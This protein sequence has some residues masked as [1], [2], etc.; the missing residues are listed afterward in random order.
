[1]SVRQSLLALLDGGESYGYQLR[2]EF[3]RRTGGTWPVNIGQVYSTLDRLERDG[4]VTAGARNQDGQRPYTITEAG[5]GA[6]RAWFAEP[7]LRSGLARDELAMKLALAVSRGEEEVRNVIQIQ[8][9]ATLRTLQDLTRAKLAGERE[10]GGGTI[11]DLAGE[12]VL[13]S[14]IFQ[15]EAEARWLDHAEAA[16]TRRAAR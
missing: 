13:E 11:D 2:T 9:G 8:R 12:L 16:L 5:R 14:L 15:V 4:L 3:E 7:V 10:D 1:V 6:V